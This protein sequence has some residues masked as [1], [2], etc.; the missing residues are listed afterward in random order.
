M[1]YLFSLSI[2]LFFI[3]GWAMGYLDEKSGWRVTGG[4]ILAS[5]GIKSI[6]AIAVYL[7]VF[8]ITVIFL[9]L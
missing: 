9:N 7:A 8:S 6:A 5:V 3:V 4:T 1:I 2:V